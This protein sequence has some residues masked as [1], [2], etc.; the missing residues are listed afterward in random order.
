MT[1]LR[2]PAPQK[3]PS[4]SR[5]PRRSSQDA[6]KQRRVALNET[7]FEEYA[8]T[9]DPKLR[10]ELIIVNSPLVKYVADRVASTLPQHV[11]VADLVSYGIIGLIKAID[12][13]D[14]GRGVKFTTYAI[15]RIRGSIIDELRTTTWA[16][17]AVRNSVR[18]L[19]TTTSSLT[20]TL[21]RAPTDAE[22]A[23]SMGI[24]EE[25]L[26]AVHQHAATRVIAI[27]SP[28]RSQGDT[29]R[30][31]LA[32]VVPDPYEGPEALL[33]AKDMRERIL[34]IIAGMAERE[35]T[36]MVLY[37][38]ERLT[39]AQIGELLG[40]T[41]SRVCQLRARAVLDIRKTLA[42]EGVTVPLPPN[43]PTEPG[44]SPTDSIGSPHKTE[45]AAAREGQTARR[46]AQR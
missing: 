10:Q 38:I 4:S 26:H 30:F 17:R 42:K 41:E 23:S 31:A 16:P 24:S 5:G 28:V 8:R 20:A 39:L 37:Y 25:E 14:P 1:C 21:G 40:I 33:E 45:K 46:D 6:A 44:V 29:R 19:D 27:D 36:I 22:V 12:R 35:R 3:H 43:D 13:Y 15:P 7:L 11:D 34:K 32:D 18:S 9:R 2:P